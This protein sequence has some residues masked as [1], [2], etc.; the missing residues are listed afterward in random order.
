MSNWRDACRLC[1][2][3]P[4]EAE[5]RFAV[6]RLKYVAMEVDERDHQTAEGVVFNTSK[7]IDRVL[8]ALGSTGRTHGREMLSL[9]WAR[10]DPQACK[11]FF[12][13]LGQIHTRWLTDMLT[14]HAFELGKQHISKIHLFHKDDSRPSS[15]YRIIF[16]LSDKPHDRRATG[17]IESLFPQAI[18]TMS[19]ETPTPRNS[20]NTSFTTP[21][22]PQM[23]GQNPHQAPEEINSLPAQ[24]NL[25]TSEVDPGDMEGV[26]EVHQ[27][28]EE[29]NR[30]P[31]QSNSGGSVTPSHAF[32]TVDSSQD[33]TQRTSEVDSGDPEGIDM[34]EVART[35][36]GNWRYKSPGGE[37]GQ[38]A[39]FD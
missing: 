21:P 7:A 16:E 17:Y 19:T 35:A 32:S 25:G 1:Y 9:I 10:T 18:P 24:P 29:I 26:E 37:Y 31:V 2:Y 5:I 39:N 11:S 33:G 36:H 30:L 22:Q 38:D 27:A 23:P 28:P 13:M 4:V 6:R 8:H 12:L 20:Q 15:H 34:E 14:T 3:Y